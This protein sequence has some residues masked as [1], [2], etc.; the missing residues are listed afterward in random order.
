M[1]F[2]PRFFIIV[3]ILFAVA[4]CSEHLAV[5]KPYER[6]RLASDKM[7]FTPME[8]ASEHETHVLLI[9]EASEGGESS[10]QGGCGCR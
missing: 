4:A 3:L 7:L 6:E 10:F 2:I 1:K 8:V 5:V 9:R